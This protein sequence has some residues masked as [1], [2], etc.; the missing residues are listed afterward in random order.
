MCD[1]L[2]GEF[3]AEEGEQRGEL[4][5]DEEAVAVVDGFG[6]ELGEGLEFGGRNGL[7]RGRGGI[8]AVGRFLNE[9]R[10][11][12]DLAEA[13]E[14]G[15]GGELEA[16]FAGAA[17]GEV[18]ELALGGFLSVAVELGLRRGEIAPDDL[19]DFFGE[20]GGDG[21]FGAAEDVGR[22]LGAEALVEPGA[23]VAADAGGDF[24][25]VAGE[26][27]FEE[28]A[29]VVEGVF[30]RRAGEEETA[31]GAEGAEGGGVLRAAIFYVLGLVGDHDREIDGREQLLVAGERAIARDDEIVSGEVGGG[32]EAVV[33][34]VNEN[35]EGG[36]EADGFAAPVFEERGGGDDERGGEDCRL[37]S[38]DCR[39]RGGDGGAAELKRGSCGFF[40][41]G[42]FNFQRRLDGGEE[43]E[44][45][46]GFTEA[47]FVGED[48]AEFGAVEVPEP[49]D[50]E[51]LIGA[52]LGVEVGG[53]G[54]GGEAGE[55]AEG[56]AAGL[57]RLGRHPAGGEFFDDGFGLGDAGG[58]HALGAAGGDGGGRIAGD[59]AL[60]G[61]EFLE[62]L[63][64]DEVNLA[65]GF[66]VAA[67]G[68]DG[69][70]ERGVVGGAGFEAE[71]EGVAA[72]G[73]LGVGDDFGGAETRGVF[74]EVFGEVGVEAGAEP[75]ALGG[76]EVEG[77]VAVA[78]PPFARGRIEG[79]AVGFHQVEGA[80]VLGVLGRG[81]GEGEEVFGTVHQQRRWRA[82]I[83]GWRLAIADG[84]DGFCGGCGRRRWRRGAEE[85]GVT[86]DAG[87]AVVDE[88][89]FLAGGGGE[90]T[91]LGASELKEGGRGGGAAEALEVGEDG[92]EARGG[93]NV[94]IKLH[95]HRD[96][97]ADDGGGEVGWEDEAK[98]TAEEEMDCFVAGAPRNDKMNAGCGNK[99][100]HR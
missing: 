24:L 10:V 50:A 92:E 72:G 29:E 97:V 32:G 19:L 44:G 37:P 96:G 11:A 49:G 56:G 53:D 21:E 1:V 94:G 35:A 27:E 89:G 17:G 91:E 90:V 20:L 78:E 40:Q 2:G 75:F 66:E 61:G 59:G 86:P 3:F 18:E 6:E 45:L 85:G 48:A 80:G 58:A 65:A 13:E 98:H 8:G 54:C 55:I 100:R 83:A 28:G 5:K 36:S 60:G 87:L 34:V 38:G 46:E 77:L 39:L 71:G 76:E 42:T 95:F 67:V 25:Q 73:F 22:G 57:P 74:F 9:A 31:A 81:E 51:S 64:R 82:G 43:G 63:G 41:L 68:G 62:L 14:L 84:A 7:R 47:H 33:A 93:R 99:P 52:E 15:E 79:E 26:E 88:D 23:F 69:V 30:E 4:G 12:A 70:A 16:A